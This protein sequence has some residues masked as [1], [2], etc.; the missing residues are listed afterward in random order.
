MTIAVRTKAFKSGNSVAV[1]LPKAVAFSEGTELEIM[2]YGD[3][4]TIR[5][6]EPAKISFKEMLARL[7]ELPKP[8]SVEVRDIEEIPERPG[9]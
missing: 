5:P 6:V 8:G 1:R 7:K 2:R 4:V 3:V 9:L